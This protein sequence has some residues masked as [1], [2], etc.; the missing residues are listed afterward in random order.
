MKSS[1][2]GRQLLQ[3]VRSSYLNIEITVAVFKL[4][5]K[6]SDEDD[7]LSINDIGLLSAVWNKFRNLQGILEGPV[8]LL[9]F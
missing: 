8:D 4:L 1:E 3:M 9:L 2:I 7:K 5:G 6:F